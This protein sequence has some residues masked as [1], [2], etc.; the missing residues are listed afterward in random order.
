M[1]MTHTYVVIEISKRAFDEIKAA[2]ERGGDAYRDHFQEDVID[3]H[4]LAVAVGPGRRHHRRSML[5]V[6]EK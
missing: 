3:M 2:L 1:R 6:I 4:G 5:R